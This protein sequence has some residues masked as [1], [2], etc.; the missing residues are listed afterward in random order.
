MPN[1]SDVA[2]VL[3]T[4]KGRYEALDAF[5]DDIDELS[6]PYVVPGVL[7]LTGAPRPVAEV[8]VEQSHLS[9]EVFEGQGI[10]R[11][12]LLPQEPKP[13]NTVTIGAAMG[14]ALGAAIGAASERKEGLLGGLALGILVGG[15][16][17]A[18][19]TPVDRALALQFDSVSGSWRLYDG[20]LR[21]WAKRA[22]I[23]TAQSR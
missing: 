14:G 8:W 15:I 16:L 10:A 20:P 19:A 7:M 9:I 2:Q 6:S 18:V 4:Y 17:G 11:F 23:P 12:K 3:E 22:L 21:S 1:L 5:V 13:Q